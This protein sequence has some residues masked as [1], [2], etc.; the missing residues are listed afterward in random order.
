MRIVA[1]VLYYSL[2]RY[3]PAT[4]NG[5]RFLKFNRSLRSWVGK[6]VFDSCGIGLNIER[7]ASFGTGKYIVIGNYSCLGVNCNVRGP[8]EMGNHV[9]MGPDV[10]IITTN[11]VTER[12]DIPIGD[13]GMCAPRKVTIGSDVWIGARVTILPGVTIGDGA[14]VA[15]GAVVT[16]DVPSL[17]VVGG[18][19]ARII[20]YRS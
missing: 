17:A 8:L 5:L 16:A 7:G 13:Q 1:L 10:L 3:F 4:N 9:L 18:V 19:P 14:I 6:W 12:T 20:R 15:A 2:L 11:H